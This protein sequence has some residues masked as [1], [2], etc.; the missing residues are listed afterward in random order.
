VTRSFLDALSERVLVSDGA[1]GTMLYAR[2]IFLN[3]CFDELNLTQPDLVAEV[4]GEYVRAGADV[5]ET[6]TFG[7]NRFKLSQFG[8]ADKVRTINVQG[9]RIA[10]HAARETAW[11][12]GSIGP[13]GVRIEP[14]GRTG[15]DEAEEAFRDQAKAL[16]EGGIDL[17][18]LETFRDVNELK[19]A[20]RAARSVGSFP[21][22]AQMTTED[23]GNTL[24]GTP[25]ETFAPELE[26]AGA[27][28]I[29]VN[30]SVGPAA[31]LET[32]ET[33]A[34]LT[35]RGL[36]AQPNA[37]RPRDVDGRNLY[38][39]SPEYMAMYARRFITAGAR[40]VGGCCGTT[41]EHI[42]QIAAAV[43]T[44]TPAVGSR[45]AASAPAADAAKPAAVVAR[46][47]K[48]ALGR[49]LA[50]GQFVFIAEVAAPRG[51]D[52][53][54]A[55]AQ[56]RRFQ[57]LGVTAV[58]VT[59]YPKSGARASA[60]ALAGLIEDQ[61]RV[62]T[63]VHYT[64]RDRRLIGMQSDLVGAHATGI[65]NVLLTTGN[66]PPGADYAD[67]TSVFDVDAIGLTNLVVRLNR[68]LDIAGQPIGAPTRF[69][70]GVGINPFATKMDA[71]WR[72]LDHKVEAGAEFIVTPPILDLN[73]FGAILPRLQERGL[74]IIAGIVALESLRQAEFLASEVVGVHVPNQL[75]DRLRR[76][77]DPAT[78]AMAATLEIA[79]W[80]RERVQG[81]QMTPLHG[82]PANVERLLTE[83]G[84][85]DRAAST[86]RE[87]R[88]A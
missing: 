33:M 51:L 70:V 48:S 42:R 14:W 17:F 81:L 31:M 6:N 34:R 58:N 2:G 29:G 56:A 44:M 28:V 87:T 68:G 25:P 19:A 64:C 26:R 82:S 5:I 12:A 88:P 84:R 69:H 79:R 36:A 21:I 24:D 37:G 9:A 53:S 57:D 13:L 59:D 76:S 7:A 18:M 71:E 10:R 67:A 39:C 23:D 50:D 63:L 54:G 73:G 49:A 66:P 78:D 85:D 32:I 72:R 41:P 30:C 61:A 55:I 35:G 75:L 38:L 60:L 15:V 77:A 27:D 11:V 43:R 80:L 22:V 8:L 52:L 4:H 83:L 45:Q 46:R 40:L 1:M 74:P 65:R 16:V 3:R 47:E 62:E 86:N 20:I